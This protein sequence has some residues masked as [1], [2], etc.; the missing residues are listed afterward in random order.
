[1]VTALAAPAE[2]LY[3]IFSAHIRLLTMPI[4][5][6][7]RAPTPSSGFSGNQAC[8][9]FTYIPAGTH[10]YTQNK[11]FLKKTFSLTFEQKDTSSQA[12]GQS[13]VGF[14]SLSLFSSPSLPSSLPFGA[15]VAF[16]VA[17]HRWLTIGPTESYPIRTL[18]SFWFVSLL[19][20]GR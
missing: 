1:M 12:R 14:L 8:K 6:G 10:T 3:S 2:D 11:S 20:E 7:P 19:V 17:P 15:R 18:V 4:T 16:E 13:G 9:W 5:L